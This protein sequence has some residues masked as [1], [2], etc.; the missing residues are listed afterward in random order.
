MASHAHCFAGS[1]LILFCCVNVSLRQLH[2]ICPHCTCTYIVN[3][4]Q[5][6]RVREQ[7]AMYI[8]M[9]CTTPR[10]VVVHTFEYCAFIH[11]PKYIYI[12]A[13]V[14]CRVHR[15][16][17]LES[18]CAGKVAVFV[19]ACV[20]GM[21]MYIQIHMEFYNKDGWTTNCTVTV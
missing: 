20:H 15:Q 5:T 17:L 8:I 14:T 10:R 16:V 21:I 3:S 13:H 1:S 12:S 4:Q 2:G 7:A 9:L 11:E 18:P 6:Y 19:H